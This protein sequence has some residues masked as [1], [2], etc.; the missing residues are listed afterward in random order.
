MK[1][2]YSLDLLKLLLAYVVAFFHVGILIP[3]GPTV[4]V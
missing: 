3:L 4:A 1:R 2:M